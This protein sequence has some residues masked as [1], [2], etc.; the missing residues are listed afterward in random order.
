ME[1]FQKSD[2]ARQTAYNELKEAQMPVIKEISKI[3]S[4][5]QSLK[6]FVIELR[7]KNIKGEQLMSALKEFGIESLADLNVTFEK[8]VA[9]R[10]PK[11]TIE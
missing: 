5:I 7:D 6:D 9:N 2:N 8:S 3:L 4:A 11:L 10:N 1:T